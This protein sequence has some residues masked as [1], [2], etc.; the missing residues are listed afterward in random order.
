M[1]L[2]GAMACSS[3]LVRLGFSATPLHR[4]DKRTI[5]HNWRFRRGNRYSPSAAA[6]DGAIAKASI[7]MVTTQEGSFDR[8]LHRMGKVELSPTTKKRETY[9]SRLS[10]QQHQPSDHLVGNNRATKRL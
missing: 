5:L 4:A 9:C 3:A 1:V 6:R 2:E 7:K 8:N 10:L